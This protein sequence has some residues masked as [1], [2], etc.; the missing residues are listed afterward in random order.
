MKG[1]L[2]STVMFLVVKFL[3]PFLLV[4]TSFT[5]QGGGGRPDCPLLSKN[6]C[7]YECEFFRV[8][9]TRLRNVTVVYIVITWLP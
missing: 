7:V 6:N 4:P 9:K 2:V 3:K 8:F 5:N 1:D